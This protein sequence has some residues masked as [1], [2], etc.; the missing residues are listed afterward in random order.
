M[1]ST[2]A[3]SVGNAETQTMP[4]TTEPTTCVNFDA[5][6]VSDCQAQAMPVTKGLSTRM[7]VE[8]RS[9]QIA[10]TNLSEPKPF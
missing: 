10:E 9:V 3:R 1:C 2:D 6:S 4:A 7:S 5:S 8:V